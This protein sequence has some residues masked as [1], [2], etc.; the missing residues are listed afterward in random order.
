MGWDDT[1]VGGGKGE[2][3]WFGLVLLEWKGEEEGIAMDGRRED[4]WADSK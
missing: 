4:K 2:L 1:Q 3:G